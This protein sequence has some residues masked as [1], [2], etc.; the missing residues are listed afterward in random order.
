MQKFPYPGLMVFFFTLLLSQ[1][2]TASTLKIVRV[3][4]TGTEVPVQRQVV[5]TFNRSVVPIGKMERSDNEIPITITPKLKCQWR[6]IDR[7]SLACQLTDNNKT[8]LATKYKIVVK[9]A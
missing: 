9:P 7:S 5:F 3:K 8:S 4:P 1:V 2:A 6:W